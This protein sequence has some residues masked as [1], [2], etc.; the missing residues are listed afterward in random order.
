MQVQIFL[1]LLGYF[2]QVPAGYIDDSR[3]PAFAACIS[4]W[5]HRLCERQA[6]AFIPHI[7]CSACCVT[8]MVD[9]IE[10]S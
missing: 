8:K 1:S 10:A 4:P 6:G 2:P 3:S 7:Y 5:Y 9:R